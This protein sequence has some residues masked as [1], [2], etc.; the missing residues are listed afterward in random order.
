MIDVIDN[1]VL[2]MQKLVDRGVLIPKFSYPMERNFPRPTAPAFAS[3]RQLEE[4]NPG[5]DKVE[6]YQN[7][8]KM[9]TKVTGVR[10]VIFEVLFTEGSVRAGQFVSSFR[11]QDML[12]L[13]RHNKMAIL[14]ATPIRNENLTMET[15]WEL[16]DGLKV[17]TLVNREW[18]FESGD[19]PLESLDVNGVFNDANNKYTIR[20]NTK[21]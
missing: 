15:N 17:V 7:G 14:T 11:R 9:F 16:R 8:N 1:D 21:E 20:V 10:Y 12:D 18:V 5:Q 19:G 2:H 13:M 3:V 4:I 6:V